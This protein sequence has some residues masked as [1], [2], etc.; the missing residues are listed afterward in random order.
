MGNN[1]FGIREF[2]VEILN[3]VLK[4][5]FKNG[6]SDLNGIISVCYNDTELVERVRYILIACKMAKKGYHENIIT[7]TE[8]T[9]ESF[10]LNFFKNLYEK[11]E[12]ERKLL[13]IETKKMTWEYK[14]RYVYLM[15]GIL[16]V[17]LAIIEWYVCRC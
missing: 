17:I 3:K 11:E 4:L 12:R 7:E 10:Y 2:E 14:Y 9:K 5:L 13:Y 6:T 15:F 1:N 16:G 8:R